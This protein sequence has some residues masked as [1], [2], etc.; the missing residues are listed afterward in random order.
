VWTAQ[1]VQKV[2]RVILER[3]VLT[4][5]T[6]HKGHKVTQE[7]TGRTVHRERMG[8]TAL[9]ALTALTVRG[10]LSAVLTGRY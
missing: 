3:T 4:E 1:L 10:C 7:R 6:A 9:T 8:R 2:R 5:R